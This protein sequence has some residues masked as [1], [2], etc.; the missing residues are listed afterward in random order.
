MNNTP[1]D[2]LP[3][4]GNAL[5]A[6]PQLDTAVRRFSSLYGLDYLDDRTVGAMLAERQADIRRTSYGALVWVS[7]LAGT[8]GFIWFLW[9]GLSKPENIAVAIGPPAVLIVL[10]VAGFVRARPSGSCGTRTSRATGTCSL[11]R[12]LTGHR[13]RTSLTG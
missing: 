7:S 9:A 5:T 3:V 6:H 4:S 11:R 12:S 1:S 10:A 13:S 8:S 2:L